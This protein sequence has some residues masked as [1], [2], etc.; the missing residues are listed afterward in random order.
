MLNEKLSTFNDV[1]I[2]DSSI[3]RLYE[4]ISKKW[5]AARTRR[6]AAGVKVSLLV[7]AVA[8][9]PKRVA[10]FAE[11]RNELKTLN[12]RPWVRFRMP[13]SESLMSSR[14]SCTAKRTGFRVSTSF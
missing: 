10:L 9:G 13:P 6:V 11:S 3:V 7:S 2:Q 12:I 14:D 5:T 8:D 4:S 1:L